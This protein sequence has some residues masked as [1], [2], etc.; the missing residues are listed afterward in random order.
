MDSKQLVRHIRSYARSRPRAR[1]VQ[2]IYRLPCAIDDDASAA[3]EA[4]KGVVARTAMTQLGRL[5][6]RG[7]LDG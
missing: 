6:D 5:Y 7:Q 4:V 3:R 1:T 2:F